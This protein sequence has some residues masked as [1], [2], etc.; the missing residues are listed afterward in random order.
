MRISCLYRVVVLQLSKASVSCQLAFHLN[1]MVACLTKQIWT[2]L[3]ALCPL[4]W[5]NALTLLQGVSQHRPADVGKQHDWITLPSFQAS[6]K[7]PVDYKSKILSTTVG[8]NFSNSACAHITFTVHVH[9]LRQIKLQIPVDCVEELA[10]KGASLLQG[11]LDDLC[12]SLLVPL[13]KHKIPACHS[14]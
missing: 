13:L 6:T 11:L 8:R 14:T 5:D 9:L 4:D 1:H 7:Q 12:H 2:L 10:I 3:Q